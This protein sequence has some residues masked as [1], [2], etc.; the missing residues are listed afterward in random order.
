[1]KNILKPVPVRNEHYKMAIIL[2]TVVVIFE[3][4]CVAN[5]N[6][7]KY[8]KY[9]NV[10]YKNVRLK[11]IG[12]K[13]SVVVNEKLSNQIY[14]ILIA[15]EPKKFDLIYDRFCVGVGNIN[16]KPRRKILVMLWPGIFKDICPFKFD[17]R[18]QLD[19]NFD[20]Q[21]VALNISFD[22]FW[23]ASLNSVVS[24]RIFDLL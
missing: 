14:F 18:Q 24:G 22:R 19:V 15:I 7:R 20:A 13:L 17:K 8:I 21:I 12:N 3:E 6:M 10:Y 23:H 5:I 9:Q 2:E 1:M 11:G 4:F 16:L